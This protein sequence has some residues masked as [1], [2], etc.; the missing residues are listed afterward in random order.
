M[1]WVGGHIVIE[2][3]HSFGIGLPHALLHQLMHL[4]EPAG[5]FATWAAEAGGA[6]LFGLTLGA[7]IVAALH[8]APGRKA[9]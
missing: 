8:L 5:G 4:A 3:L 7:L 6:G 9:H 1:L 2:G